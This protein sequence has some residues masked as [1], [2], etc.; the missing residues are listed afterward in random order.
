MSGIAKIT[1]GMISPLGGGDV[2]FITKLVYPLTLS[3]KKKKPILILSIKRKVA[4]VCK[5]V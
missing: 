4:I 2:T 3:L 1:K 5:R